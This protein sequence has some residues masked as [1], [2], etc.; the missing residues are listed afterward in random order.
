MMVPLEFG[1]SGGQGGGLCKRG[2]LGG[3]VAIY[4]I[5]LRGMAYV[6]NKEGNTFSPGLYNQERA[7]ETI[8]IV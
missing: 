7:L 8:H 2:G 4:Q 3:G 6:M 1:W 5:W